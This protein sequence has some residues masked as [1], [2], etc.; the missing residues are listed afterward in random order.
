MSYPGYRN[1]R[2]FIGQTHLED[3]ATT[4]LPGSPFSLLSARFLP[5]FSMVF[6]ILSKYSHVTSHYCHWVSFFRSSWKSASS[7]ILQ[8]NRICLL[9]KKFVCFSYTELLYHLISLHYH[10]CPFTETSQTPVFCFFFFFL[11]ELISSAQIYPCSMPIA[12]PG[13]KHCVNYIIC[14]FTIFQTA[15]AISVRSPACPEWLC[16]ERHLM[17]NN[18]SYSEII[19]CAKI[20]FSHLII[21][22]IQLKSDWGGLK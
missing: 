13:C 6:K 20:D 19:N 1:P 2:E 4:G 18:F 14:F 7:A 12:P 11:A 3:S 17:C 8:H 16:T 9:P 5:G 15:W 22:T 21:E 10:F